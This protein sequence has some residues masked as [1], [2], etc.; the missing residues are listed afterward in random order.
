MDVDAEI[1]CVWGG[2]TRRAAG[3]LSANEAA[4]ALPDAIDDLAFRV[5]VA[6]VAVFDGAPAAGGFAAVSAAPLRG[7]AAGGAAIRMTGTFPERVYCHFGEAVVEATKS[8][9]GGASCVSP[10][11]EA[12]VLLGVLLGVRLVGEPTLSEPGSWSEH[13]STAVPTRQASAKSSAW[14]YWLK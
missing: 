13:A 1:A 10:P 4:C 6:G 8:S 12:G 2:T 7:P 14:S 5:E 11:L 3:F 9:E